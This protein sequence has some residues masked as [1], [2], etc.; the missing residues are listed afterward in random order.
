MSPRAGS[1]VLRLMCFAAL[2]VS[3]GTAG[4]AS[5]FAVASGAWN[6]T[7]TWSGSSGG[8][9]GASVPV[10]GD[11]VSIGE[12]ATLRT[13]TIPANYAANASSITIG[14]ASQAGGRS[15][16][17][18]AASASLTTTGAVTVLGPNS[19]T[20]N[21]LDVGAGTATIGGALT[22]TGGTNSRQARLAISTGTATVA[23]AVTVNNANALV[24]FTGP[25]TLNVGGN[26]ASGA[27]FARGTGTVVYN[28]SGAQ[29]LGAY[30]YNNLAVDKSAGVATATGITTVAGN[31]TVPSGT[32]NLVGFDFT[33]TGTTTVGGTL[34]FATSAVGTKIFTGAVTISTGGTW[35]N[36]I[37]ESVTLNGNL[38][39]DGTFTGGSG[40]YTF[41]G[42]AIQTLTGTA[43]A[44]TTLANL[45]LNN[46]SGITLTA[47]STHNVTVAT[48]LTLTSGSVRTNDNVLYI[49]SG[50]AIAG[51]SA[52][53]FIVGNLRKPFPIAAGAT[54]RVFEVGTTTGAA[55]Y[56]P[57]SLS[58]TGV[59]TAGDVTVTSTAGAHPALASSGL[60]TTTPHKLNRYWTVSGSTLAY[61]SYSAVF[62]FVAAD[63]DAGANAQAF[64][65]A[66]YFPVAPAPGTWSPTGSNG[67]TA[68]SI[69]LS[70]LTAFGDF[71]AGEALAYNAALGRF[72]AYDPSPLTL[73]GSAHGHIRTK[74]AGTSPAATFTLTVVHLD[75][76]GTALATM[77]AATTVTVAL[78]DGST[79]S[80]VLASNC[81]TN[82]LTATPITSTT[83]AFAAAQTTGTA[84][85][86]V[87]NSYKD[88]RVRITGG[89]QTGCSGDRFAIKPNAITLS[90]AHADWQ[91]A[92]TTSALTNSSATGGAVHKAGRPFTVLATGVNTAGATTTNYDG[93]PTLKVAA[94]CVLPAGCT[95]GVLT[96]AAWSG[97]GARTGA[98]SYTEVGTFSIEF[99]DAG[100]AAVDVA[101][102]TAAQRL[103]SQ[104]G[105]ASVLGRFV[106]DHFHMAPLT[107]PVF[108]TFNTTDAT[109]S[110]GA[111]PRR[112]FTYVGQPFGYSTTPQATITARNFAGATATN[113]RG[114]LWKIGGSGVAVKDCTSVANTCVYTTA[115][116]ATGGT[117]GE[118]YTY[119]L[120]T[121]ATPGWD[122]GPSKSIP[123]VATVTSNNDG[124][125]TVA[126][127]AGGRIAFQR[128]ATTPVDPF[129][130]TIANSVTVTDNAEGASQVIST[131]TPAAFGAIPF[132]ATY[133]PGGQAN[134]FFHGRLRLQ[135]ASGSHLIA[136][137]IPI[138]TQYW[139]GTAFVTN[140]L[141]HCTSISSSNV[142]LG[143]YQKNLAP[144]ETSVSVGGTFNAGLTTLR[145]SAPGAG[146]HGS[147]DVS[148]NLSFAGAGA[149]CTSGMP[150]STPSGLEHLQGAWCGGTYVRDPTARASFG[151]H[152]NS[153]R[154]IFQRENF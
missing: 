116:G 108:R 101:D 138:Q 150:A 40:V 70:G 35:N 47:G 85:L 154:V 63:L 20:V 105:G 153:E 67:N 60:D 95:N 127:A 46:A 13:V 11:I 106:P 139:N 17:L 23:G 103:V 141:D 143:N 78:I 148:I 120:D 27:T 109:C 33:V 97:T 79:T 118:S 113:Y 149:S 115:F 38:T 126:F 34:S 83:I 128:S 50:N 49:A 62:T 152:R 125:G 57:A 6:V 72:N 124:T 77:G 134:K 145:L 92:G 25:G 81:W 107:T 59:T 52:T 18:S 51:A 66:R 94:A 140:S 121:G 123:A 22:L 147:V 26:F 55:R 117:V 7:S 65:G 84:T 90:A 19:N 104:T 119:A 114:S 137:P 21:A 76:A 53:N 4:A 129:V 86:T 80:G 43:G 102:S 1:F 144:G 9:A 42:A 111:A 30:A 16:T 98:A 45:T 28:G 71:A 12:T 14:S 61:T 64:V 133:T 91:T 39:N 142:S 132:D 151:L 37:N 100:Y 130:A 99:E 122:N 48:T 54:A 29:T 110:A 89:G 75:A 68:T 56:A 36:G 74:I 3:C 93:S 41:S 131:A 32:F 2:A 31:L 5:R 135:N 87:P 58:I 73:T 146:N 88:V 82:W 24:T 112:T 136:L 69:T 15:L 8:A 96:L 10:A 44:T